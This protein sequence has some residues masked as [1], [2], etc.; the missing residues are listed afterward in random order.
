MKKFRTIFRG[1][2]ELA[3]GI[4]SAYVLRGAGLADIS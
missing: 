1:K 4:S 3:F 2:V